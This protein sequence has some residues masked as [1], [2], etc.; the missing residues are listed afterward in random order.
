MTLHEKI[1]QLLGDG[2]LSSALDLALDA[3]KNVDGDFY[4]TLILHKAQNSSNEKN[5]TH[6]IITNNDYNRT[7][8]SIQ[9]RFQ[10]TLKDFPESVLKSVFLESSHC[11]EFRGNSRNNR[12]VKDSKSDSIVKILFMSAQP[13]DKHRLN[14]E[15]DE[16]RNKLDF[17]IKN[18]EVDFLHPTWETDYESLLLRLKNDKPNVLQ[19][20][21]HG[22]K[23]GICLKNKNDGTTQLLE[24]DELI[25]VFEDRPY[26]KLV[27]LNSCFSDTQAKIISSQG[28]Y[29]LGIKDEID[30]ELS[31][32]LS[33][34][35]YLGFAAQEAPLSI[36]KAIKIGCRNFEKNYPEHKELIALWKDGAEIDYK[37]L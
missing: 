32:K 36:E 1:I 6:G 2:K 23:Q 27:F 14:S 26:L 35:F 22:T 34:K 7:K 29:V 16:V 3:I 24:N 20:A 18:K 5:F 37:S 10:E 33:E 8:S 28:I 19:Y 11:S 17:S 25:E 9:Y 13:V 15:F 12:V 21:G 31:V 30:N 4:N